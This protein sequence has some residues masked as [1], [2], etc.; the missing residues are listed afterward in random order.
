MS[1]R[2]I[3]LSKDYRLIV[4]RENVMFLK[5]I[6]AREVKLLGAYTQVLRTSDFQGKPS[7]RYSRGR[8][9]L[10]FLLY[11]NKFSSELKSLKTAR[12]FNNNNNNNNNNNKTS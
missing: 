10:L 5:Q 11:T 6:L 9:T 4:T 3:F 2:V 7:G 12:P 8:S 1:S